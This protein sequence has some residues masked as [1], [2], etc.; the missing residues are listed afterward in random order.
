V[1]KRYKIKIK[2]ED[3]MTAYYRRKRFMSI[4]RAIFILALITAWAE[5]AFGDGFPHAPENEIYC[6]NCHSLHG[7]PFII[8][9]GLDQLLVCQACHNPTGRAS[10]KSDVAFHVTRNDS[11]DCGTCHDPHFPTEPNADHIRADVLYPTVFNEVDYPDIIPRKYINT[12]AP[13]NGICEVCHTETLFHRNESSGEHVHNNETPCN[14]CHRHQDGFLSSCS[15]CSGCHDREQ[16]GRRAVLADFERNSHHV[17]GSIASSDCLVC[18][19]LSQHRL[20]TVILKDPDLGGSLLYSFDPYDP[21]GIADF[22]TNCHDE[23]GAVSGNGIVPFSDGETV[24][25]IKGGPG[26]RWEDSA[27][28]TIGYP[29]NNGNPVSC[30]GDGSITGCHSNG[31]GS[32]NTKLL[33]APAGTSIHD[34]CYN[35]HTDGRIMN[36]ALSGEELADDI[37][38]AFGL[39]YVHDLGTSFGANGNTFELECTSCHNPH[40]VTGRHWDTDL[41]V[42]PITIPD[43]YADPV[44][45]PR[46]MSTTLWGADVGEKMDDYAGLGT[47]RTP[48][49]DSL[50][51]ADL[52]DY[53]TFCLECHSQPQNEFGQHGAISWG[54]D[55]PHGTNSANVPNGGHV[56]PDWYS[57]GKA[58]SWT[59]DD[60]TG[61]EEECW[62]VLTRGKGEM[63]WT[64]KPYNQE[65]RIAGA[66]FIMNC[67]DCHEAHGSTVNST[68]REKVNDG[69]GTW[70]WNEMCNNCHYYYSDWHAGMSCGTASC[71]GPNSRLGSSNSIHGMGANTGSSGTRIFYTDLVVDMAFN[72]NL[73]DAG[74]WRMS[75]VWRNGSGSFVSGVSGQAIEVNDNPIEIGTRNEF[76]STDEGRH[77]T[78]RYTEMKY[79]MTLEAW[80]YPTSDVGGQKRILAKHTYWDGGYNFTLKKIDGTLRAALETNVTGGGPNW[81]SGGWDP[82]DCNG[83]RGAYSSV[84]I[85]LNEWTHVAATYD[86]TDLDR[87]PLD[88]SVGRIRIYVNGVDVTWSNEFESDCWAQPGPGEELMFPYSDHSPDNEEI[89]Y[90][91]HWCASALSVGGVNW[92]DPDN[93]FVGRLDE[94]KIWNIT[95]DAS[96]FEQYRP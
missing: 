74:T 9:T 86:Y 7:D 17:W 66:N 68:I 48:R 54:G 22:C 34:F 92:S 78:W 29:L 75:G 40:I 1:L 20:G 16:G 83:L 63:I 36:V 50:S 64:R 30:Y 76:W 14:E 52:P 77:G 95:Q 87:D 70:I 44:F 24:P 73:N 65:D 85:P 2:G 38:E 94:L 57:C 4:I 60:C 55:E 12:V 47:Y 28:G 96:Y 5:S 43:F 19:D 56:C 67:T 91:E 72:G 51:G 81:G 31:H 26:N 10:A 59:F 89:C 46:A 41:G 53:V 62:P 6:F 8:P 27:H 88:P 42:T 84:S 79:N 32:D 25:D 3:T 80:V 33:S 37:E 93:N 71:H 35:C 15:D 11:I 18:H 45:N 58:E 82:E 90:N 13:Y 49:G 39:A 61:T 23:D 69:P 21:S